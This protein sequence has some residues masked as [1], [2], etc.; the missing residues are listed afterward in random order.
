MKR[1][2]E[3]GQVGMYKISRRRG[4]K[5]VMDADGVKELCNSIE[6]EFGGG[7]GFQD[8]AWGGTGETSRWLWEWMENSNWQ[9]RL[10]HLETML[11]IWGGG[12]IQTMNHSFGDM[13][14]E[15]VNSRG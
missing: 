13:Q 7:C 12:A 5:I 6:R 8:Q 3:R 1:N 14:Y 11:D 4:N 9:G 2:K 10:E 15:V